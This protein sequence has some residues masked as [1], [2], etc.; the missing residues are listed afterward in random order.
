MHPTNLTAILLPRHFRILRPRDQ[1]VRRITIMVEI[2][3][4]E[5][6]G[7]RTAVGTKSS[8]KKCGTWVIDLGMPY[9]F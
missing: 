7:R 4:H 1:Q 2:S 3:D 8:R 9:Q 5:S 6:S